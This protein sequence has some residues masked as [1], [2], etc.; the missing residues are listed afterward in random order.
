MLLHVLFQGSEATG[1]ILQLQFLTGADLLSAEPT[2]NNRGPGVRLIL[3]Q[4]VRHRAV[5][6]LTLCRGEFQEISL[7]L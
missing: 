1:E 2:S 6:R 7:P 3:P 4:N 5:L